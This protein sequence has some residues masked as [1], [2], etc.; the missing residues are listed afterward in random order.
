VTIK[1]LDD[2]NMQF[3]VDGAERISVKKYDCVKITGSKL[4]VK[5]VKTSNRSF[6]D[7][8]RYKMMGN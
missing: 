5:T 7:T 6:Y 4:S 3:S 2:A 1:I 8:L